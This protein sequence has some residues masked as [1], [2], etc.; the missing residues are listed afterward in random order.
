MSGA[1]RRRRVEGAARVLPRAV[2]GLGLL[3]AGGFVAWCL[4]FRSLLS[5]TAVV[6]GFATVFLPALA[7]VWAGFQ[8]ARGGIS[9]DRYGRVVRW[10]FGGAIVFLAVNGFVMALFPW[11]GLAGNLAWAQFSLNAGG[12]AGFL[13]GYVEARAIQREVEATAAVARAAQ[14]EEDRELLTYL[15]DL[16]RHEV[17]NS[18]QII[19]GHA[20]LLLEEADDSTRE[21][22]EAI[23]RESEKLT[24]VIDDIRAMLNATQPSAGRAVVALDDVLSD[25]IADVERRFDD[26]GV[27]ASVPD[28][29]RVEGNEGIGWIFANL[30]ENAVEHNDGESPRVEVTV[31]TTDETVTVRIADD[32]PGIP[33]PVRETLFDRRTDNHG[34]GL[35]L[36]RILATRYGGRVDL[37]ETG[38][39]GSVF[40]VTLSRAG[41]GRTAE[42]SDRHRNGFRRRREPRT[43]VDDGDD[44][45]RSGTDRDE[46]E[47]T[48]RD[49]P[50]AID[51][52]AGRS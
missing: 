34:L 21:S 20:T 25:E 51:S 41:D 28:G 38:P 35:Y 43:G 33:T 30:L 16:L 47:R 31:A 29:V 1:A 27:E 44:L 36:V 52:A 10:S 2:S 39:D 26:V 49:R 37:A 9:R 6:V 11:N 8:L 4:W 13:V 3:S 18:T 48:R 32:G 15:S 45:R 22:L 40:A 50:G 7:L 14:L 23:D 46:T 12:G 42:A 5:P 19:G 17:L 24:D